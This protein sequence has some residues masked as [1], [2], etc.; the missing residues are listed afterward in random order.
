MYVHS[1]AFVQLYSCNVYK[2]VVF[3][4]N[5]LSHT[6]ILV[7]Y[8]DTFDEQVNV[9]CNKILFDVF[10]PIIVNIS[11]ALTRLDNS[12]HRYQVLNYTTQN[13]SGILRYECKYA[14]ICDNRIK[15]VVF[16]DRAKIRIRISQG[17]N[18]HSGP[19]SLQPYMHRL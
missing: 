18:K 17:I 1:L 16:T 11:F 12:L 5:V 4:L 15:G 10:A 6:S 14:F 9:L 19:N 13:Q 2:W 8:C 3:E 7:F